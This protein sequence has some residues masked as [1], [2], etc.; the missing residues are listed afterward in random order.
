MDQETLPKSTVHLRVRATDAPNPGSCPIPPRRV[1]HTHSGQ[2]TG[3][4]K[5][6]GPAA[7]HCSGR[8]AAWGGG[9]AA[10]SRRSAD[11]GSSERAGHL[12]RPQS[13]QEGLETPVH[14]LES[15]SRE[16]V[17][18]GLPGHAQIPSPGEPGMQPRD[19]CLPWRGKL[20]PGHTLRW[21]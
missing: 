20:G 5:L 4:F 7:A 10:N 8:L 11:P 3:Y 13:L 19:P 2:L 14:T 12:L 15:T 16:K 1:P 18:P 6:H 17:S 9:R 21:C